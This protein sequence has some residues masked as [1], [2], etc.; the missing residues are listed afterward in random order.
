MWLYRRVLSIS[1]TAQITNVEVLRKMKKEREAINTVKL[2]KLQYPGHL[3]RLHL[4]QSILQG[5]S[6]IHI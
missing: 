6:L 2:T 3:V 5:L 1:W 4:L